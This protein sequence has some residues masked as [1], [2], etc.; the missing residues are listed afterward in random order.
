[1]SELV[2]QLRAWAA[3]AHPDK[4]IALSPAQVKHLLKRWPK[5]VDFLSPRE[6]RDLTN[7]FRKD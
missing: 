6:R 3:D 2:D 4:R 7:G 5:P 1:M